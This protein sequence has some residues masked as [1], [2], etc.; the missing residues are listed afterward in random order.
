MQQF[1]YTS[2]KNST[3]SA[4]IIDA[5]DLLYTNNF[6][7]FCIV[8]SDSDF[9]RLACRIR[10]SGL[11]VYGF[12]ERKTPESFVKDCDKFIYIE[13]LKELEK[14]LQS[15]SETVLVK[16]AKQVNKHAKKD[17]EKMVVNQIIVG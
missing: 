14:E 1:N 3:D 2:G 11:L 7:G 12:R 9:T 13:I 4:L 16:E 6:D 5:R 17:L 15:L 8:S 10:E